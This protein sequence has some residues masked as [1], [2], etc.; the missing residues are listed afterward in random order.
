MAGAFV[1]DARV[2]PLVRSLALRLRAEARGLMGDLAAALDDAR[3]A[4]ELV[5]GDARAWNA[6]GIAAADAGEHADAVEAF[7]RATSVDA[8]Y[9]R[10]WNNLGNALRV[11]GRAD[12]AL[13]TFERAV[14]A[15]ARYAH[16]WANLA[17][18][19][20]DAGDESGAID[21]AKRALAIDPRQRAARLLL[22]GIDR[23]SGRLDTAIVAYEG[24]LAERPDDAPVRF[25]LAGALAERDDLDAA[26]AAYAHAAR[27]SPRLL[28]ARLGAALTLPMIPA[29]K[30][31]IRE[32]RAAFAAGL[33][34]LRDELP[35]VATTMPQGQ[36]LRELC[37]T[38]FLLAYQ[39]QDDLEL[40]SAYGDLVATTLAASRGP[41]IATAPAPRAVP[42]RRRVA[43]VS[44][45]F[46]DGTVGR[47]FE[48]W[49]TGLDPD[50]FEVVVH[51]LGA[52]SDELTGRLRHGA[53]KFVSHRAREPAEIARAIMEDS[54][55][56]IVYPELGMDA[57]TFALAS[58]RLA[59]LQ[60]SGW[61][62]PVTSGLA[63]IDL[64]FSAGAMEPADG[65]AHYRERLVRLPGL[66]TRYARPVPPMRVARDSLGLPVG[67]VLFLVPQ[68]LFKLHPDDDRRIARV[69][70]AAKGSRVVAFAG[71]HPKLTV[72]WRARLGRELDA[73]GV[74]A[75]RVVV[76]P[77]VDHD[78]YLR[79]NLAC[80]AMLDS[81][82]WSGGN[83]SLDA[84]ACGLPIATRPGAFMRGRQSAG[85]LELI[86]AADLVAADEDAL[87]ANAV[88]L[89]EDAPWR[90]E[91]S[92]RMRDGSKALFDDVEPV[93][94]LAAALDGR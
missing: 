21:A 63:T 5:P 50:R 49:I 9:A 27:T 10:A 40:Q 51:Q 20:R 53:A 22:A 66:G 85:M 35:A 30:A 32:A 55:D 31:S 79:I 1:D 11:V 62:H 52:S 72:A 24:A 73:G 26:R 33:E 13:A 7:S 75:S 91:L 6:L 78:D 36:V 83:T 47:Y 69:L 41:A 59:P 43:F 57:T 12:D 74:D 65:A 68:S 84:I 94:A 48:S 4:A 42:G 82:R 89:A 46:R 90:A 87:V 8:T 71:R 77:Q 56:C 29:S 70:A 54:P 76:L 67:P 37:W 86:G 3:R 34:R 81:V 18:A 44:A 19:R 16:G 45:F 60:C 2:S 61:G 58:L 80:D 14:G 38:N 23:R 64:M 15:D 88:R 93:A 25:A 17:V 39:G 28:R 92:A